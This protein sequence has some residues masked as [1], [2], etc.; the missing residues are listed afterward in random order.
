ML[1][2]PSIVVSVSRTMQYG[3]VGEEL[4]RAID[5]DPA[6]SSIWGDRYCTDNETNESRKYVSLVPK[7]RFASTSQ[8]QRRRRRRCFFSPAREIHRR[9]SSVANP[10]HGPAPPMPP[11]AAPYVKYSPCSRDFCSVGIAH[12]GSCGISEAAEPRTLQQPQKINCE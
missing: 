10:V 1:V 2:I 9:L 11:L 4:S 8:S 7:K 12:S 6:Y 3:Q 5:F